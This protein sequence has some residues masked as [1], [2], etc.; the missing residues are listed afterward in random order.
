MEVCI[1]GSFGSIC[2]DGWNSQDAQVICRQMGFEHEG[3]HIPFQHTVAITSLP[4]SLPPF[5]LNPLKEPLLCLMRSLA[6]LLEGSEL[7]I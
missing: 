1:E 7:E 4:P 2:D 6:Q 5:L 3:M